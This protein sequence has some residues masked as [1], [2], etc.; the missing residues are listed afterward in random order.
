MDFIL[1]A[2]AQGILKN[3][4][5]YIRITCAAAT[6]AVWAC[7]VEMGVIKNLFVRDI[8]TYIVVSTVMAFI[9]SGR[10]G[11]LKLIKSVFTFIVLAATVGGVAGLLYWNTSVGYLFRTV[12]MD[13]TGLFICLLAAMLT[14]TIVLRQLLVQKVYSGKLHNVKIDFGEVVLDVKG[15]ADTGNVLCDPV[16]K[17][18][19]HVI[20][21]SCIEKAFDGKTCIDKDCLKLHYVPFNSVGCRNGCMPVI[22]AKKI[23]IYEC[24]DND[25][26][27][28]KKCICLENVPVGISKLKLSSDG[29]YQMLINSEVMR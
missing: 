25:C 8:L 21:K 26:K 18:P 1:L 27:D 17:K 12:A 28:S 9:C 19:V 13:S 7:I 3:S 5:T 11:V 16:C 2:I 10:C 6:G 29:M 22:M 4:A 24:G 20:E 15:L 14:L 23:C